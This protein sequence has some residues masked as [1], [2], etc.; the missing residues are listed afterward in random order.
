[1]QRNTLGLLAL[2]A[3]GGGLCLAASAANAQVV[4]GNGSTSE[5]SYV[6]DLSTI[7]PGPFPVP[8]DVVDASELPLQSFFRPALIEGMA[9]DEPGRRLFYFELGPRLPS[10]P[11]DGNLFSLGYDDAPASAQFLGRVREASSNLFLNLQGLAYDTTRSRLY[12]AYNVGG[13]PGEGIYELDLSAAVGTGVNRVVPARLVV[14]YASLPGGESAYGVTAIDY[15]PLTDSLYVY[16]NSLDAASGV[17]RGIYRADVTTGTLDFVVA[18]PDYRRIENDVEG[19]AAGDGVVY[20]T[21]DEPGF[22]YAYDVVNGGPYRDFLSPVQTE[23]LF[24]G[25]A[26]APG[27]I[28]EPA[29]LGLALLGGAALLGRRR[30]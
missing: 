18:A 6:T 24:G 3:A 19:L 15:D 9:A 10:Q 14:P 2:A 5:P 28:P 11:S 4:L 25:A 20:L 21:T 13:V 17:Q 23:G 26:F 7:R 29:T 12:G 30:R 27:L 22:V 8:A 16:N 1:M